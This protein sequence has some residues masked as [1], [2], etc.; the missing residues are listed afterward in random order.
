MLFENL[1][2]AILFNEGVWWLCIL[3]LED[4]VMRESRGRSEGA[5][6]GV[7]RAAFLEDGKGSGM[8]DGDIVHKGVIA[9]QQMQPLVVSSAVTAHLVPAPSIV[10]QEIYLN[11][12]FALKGV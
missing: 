6:K 7:V 10:S 8:V 2:R 5:L 11:I 4:K 1:H 9:A 3:R 12:L